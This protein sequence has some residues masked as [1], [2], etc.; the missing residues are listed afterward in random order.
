MFVTTFL[1]DWIIT[2]MNYDFSLR[3][4][5]FLDVLFPF[6]ISSIYSNW[7]AIAIF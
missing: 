7:L 2:V 5:S 4:F 3:N 1:N 6:S